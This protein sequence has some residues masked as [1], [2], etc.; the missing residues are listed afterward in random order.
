MADANEDTRRK[1]VELGFLS[2]ADAGAAFKAFRTAGG[3]DFCDYL[4]Q[5]ALVTLDQAG[6]LFDD[7]DDEDEAAAEAN[8]D[9]TMVEN[10][11]DE[12]PNDDPIV[13]KVF[14]GYRVIKLL[15]KGGMGAVYVAERQDDGERVAIK[16]LPLDQASNPTWRGRFLREAR[17]QMKI[18]HENIV[19]IHSVGDGDQPY[20]IMEIVNGEPL[21]EALQDRGRFPALEVARIGRDIAN[22]L[23][24]AHK[25][26]IVHRDIKPANVLLTHEGVVKVLDFGLAKNVEMDDGLSMPGQILGTPHYMAPEQ[27]GDHAVDARCD[28]FSLGA[29]LYHLVTGVLPFSARKPQAIAR[30]VQKGEFDPPSLHV[31]DIPYDLELV[32]YR[33]LEVDRSFRYSSAQLCAEDLQRVL[34]DEEVNIPRLVLMGDEGPTERFPLIPGNVFLF[35]RSEET[36][37]YA[38]DSRSVSRKHAQIERG[39]TGFSIQD[40]GSSY[41]SFV[42]GLRVKNV[43]LRNNDMVKLG[44]VVFQFKDGGM[45]QARVAR[46]RSLTKARLEVRSLAVPFVLVLARQGDRRGVGALLE[47]L[48]PGV[49]GAL[50]DRACGQVKA[51]FGDDLAGQLREKLSARLRRTRKRIPQYLFTSTHENLGN[52]PN[53]WL[54][55]WDEARLLFP[56]QIAPQRPEPEFSLRVVKGEPE[57]RQISLKGGDA[58]FTVGREEKNRVMLLS[59]SV[60]RLHAT[61]VRLHTRIWLRDEGSRYGTLVNGERVKICFLG[62]GDKV[63]MGQVEIV[64]EVNVKDSTAAEDPQLEPEAWFILAELGHASTALGLLSLLEMIEDPTWMNNEALALFPDNSE[65]AEKFFKAIKRVYDEKGELARTTLPQIL[66]VDPEGSLASWKKALREQEKTLPRQV[67]PIG[68]FPYSTASGNF[69]V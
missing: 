39:P 6:E 61:L 4:I 14:D 51:L 62:A 44:E 27:W 63:V 38:I 42:G 54:S 36:S 22:G 29:M 13:G 65:K 48:A 20:I 66:G 10:E 64:F 55:W 25:L 41:G 37:T 15:G 59:R 7:D 57:A 47:D 68:W 9:V 18:K 33:M 35:G 31:E 1:V 26:G 5:N 43:V 16:F 23:A 40:L 17:V 67:L 28:V 2:D 3:E 8:A 34:D 24:F 32:I 50:T 60:S 45:A 49:Q 12:V 69:R 56:S 46:T 11:P 30:K 52:E 58:T 21:D 19:A 53:D